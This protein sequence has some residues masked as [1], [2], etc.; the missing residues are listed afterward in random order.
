[1]RFFG[2][3]Q[4]LD[5]FNEILRPTGGLPGVGKSPLTARRQFACVPVLYTIHLVLARGAVVPF[6]PVSPPITTRKFY[7]AVCSVRFR[8]VRYCSASSTT[9][10]RASRKGN[11]K[12]RQLL[13]Q[14]EVR[15][16]SNT[17][18]AYPCKQNTPTGKGI[19]PS[20]VLEIS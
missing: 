16:I 3:G 8:G 10:I 7:Q 4:H 19:G 5:C 14:F 17:V 11:S 6:R 20:I 18:V 1:M 13:F 12:Q 15:L 2:F 9:I